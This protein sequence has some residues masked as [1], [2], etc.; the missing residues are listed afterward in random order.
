MIDWAR[1][2]FLVAATVFYS[3]LG[4]VLLAIAYKVFDWLTPTDLGK[5]IFSEQNV[6]AAV[7]LGLFLV[8]LA[9]II[10]AAVHG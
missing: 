7:A 6:A 5:A 1:E 10:A 4:G 9:I 2:G 3:I 8:A